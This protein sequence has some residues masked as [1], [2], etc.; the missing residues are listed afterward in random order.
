MLIVNIT[1]GILA[2]Y[3]IQQTLSL[4]HPLQSDTCVLCSLIHIIFTI[5]YVF[6]IFKKKNHVPYLFRICENRIEKEGKI[7]VYKRKSNVSIYINKN[8]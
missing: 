5:R 8:T 2:I 3:S 1:K 6:F 4:I 7:I